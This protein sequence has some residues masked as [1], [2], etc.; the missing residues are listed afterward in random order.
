MWP[1]CVAL[2]F[3]EYS[4]RSPATLSR[5]PMALLLVQSLDDET[6][7][8][9]TLPRNLETLRAVVARKRNAQ[10]GELRAHDHFALPFG[11]REPSSEFLA[12]IFVLRG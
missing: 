6:L 3:F 11:Q 12:N 10:L 5:L 1:V 7:P 8:G 2:L 9:E 4:S